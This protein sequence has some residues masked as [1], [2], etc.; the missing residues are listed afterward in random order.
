MRVMYPTN[1]VRRPQAG[2]S[3]S[4]SSPVCSQFL[5]YRRGLTCFVIAPRSM[6]PE[7]NGLQ[8]LEGGGGAKWT[9]SNGGKFRTRDQVGVCFWSP[10]RATVSVRGHNYSL[11]TLTDSTQSNIRSQHRLMPSQMTPGIAS[12]GRGADETNHARISPHPDAVARTPPAAG[13][14]VHAGRPIRVLAL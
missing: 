13:A 10:Y 11:T 3:G 4:Q 14:A 7:R 1:Y 5:I 12:G 9:S 8:A 2:G 6:P